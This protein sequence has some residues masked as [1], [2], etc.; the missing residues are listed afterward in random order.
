M[1]NDIIITPGSASIQ[2]SG[3]SNASIKLNVDAS[4]SLLFSGNSGSLFGITDN[5]S[6]SLMSV[7]TVAGLPILEVFSD[8]RVNIGKYASEAIKVQSGGSDVA[9][10]SGSVMFVTSS[11]RVGVGVNT[12]VNKLDVAGN[13]SAS[14]MTAS[15]FFGTSSWAQSASNAVNSQTASYLTIA[16]TYTASNLNVTSNAVVSKL[17]IGT[18]VGSYTADIFAVGGAVTRIQGDTTSSLPYMVFQR[19][20]SFT[21]M[22]IGVANSTSSFFTAG[23]TP[24][25]GAAIIK[26]DSSN[27]LALGVGNTGTIYINAANNVGVGTNAPKNKLDVVGGMVIG[28]TY[29]GA[30]GSPTNGL[31]VQ[32]NVGIGTTT[33]QPVANPPQLQVASSGN[34]ALSVWS[35]SATSSQQSPQINISTGIAPFSTSSLDWRIVVVAGTGAPNSKLYIDSY[36]TGSAAKASPWFQLDDLGNASF[37]NSSLGVGNISPGAV[38]DVTGDARFTGN[39][40]IGGLAGTDG[41]NTVKL[42]LI[43]LGSSTTALKFQSVNGIGTTSTG[44]KVFKGF[45]RAYVDSTVTD[46]TNAFASGLYYFPL[47]Q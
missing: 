45:I 47:Y 15:L 22:S 40:G 39:V 2:F 32:G 41:T 24:V 38:L 11:G 10:G 33:V 21:D 17:G 44:A 28:N 27:G 9:L 34:S 37:P 12:P 31:L 42:T 16:N 30:W 3:S 35:T 4:G 36:R 43:G 8:N 25:Q 13:I 5:L 18:N 26:N 19:S 14:N 20:S 1:T 23:A 7:N 6:G 46:G 29:A